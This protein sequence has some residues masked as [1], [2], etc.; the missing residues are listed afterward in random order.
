MHSQNKEILISELMLF[1]VKYLSARNAKCVF[2]KEDQNL[3][4]SLIFENVLSSLT[5]L[6]T[7]HSEYF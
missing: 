5:L 4:Y 1:Y 2:D 7:F 3:L 6:K